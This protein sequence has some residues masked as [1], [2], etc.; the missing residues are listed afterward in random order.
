VSGLPPGWAEARLD[1]LAQVRLG[2]QRS[3][4][5]HSGSRMRPYLRAGN[6][7]WSG[8]DLRDVKEMN[9]TEEES[10]VYELQPGDVLVAEASGSA[11]EVGRPALWRGEIDGCCFQ[12][13]LIRVR[14]SGAQPE[15]L[16][17]FLLTEAQTGRIGRASPG[18]GIHHISGGRLAAWRVPLP[19]LA[20]Q[21][22]IVGA[23]EQQLSRLEAASTALFTAEDRI[24]LLR[25]SAS[26]S[27]FRDRWPTQP[28]AA[29]VDPERPI[30]YGILMPKEQVEDGVLYVRVRDFPAGR[31]LV[32]ELKRTSPEIANKYRRSA[33]KPDDV[34]VSIRGTFGRV[35]VVPPELDG[36]N[37]TQDT[38]R[39]AP[40]AEIDRD[41]LVAYLRSYPAQ[42]YFSV[43]ARGVA[44][45]GVNLG[46]LRAMPVPVPP[47][48]EQRRIAAEAE[49]TSSLLD[50]LAAEVEQT[51]RRCGVLRLA[52]LTRAFRGELVPQDP[53]EEPGRVLLELITAERATA[54]KP[55]R[56]RRERMPA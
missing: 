32:N 15:Y 35:A 31:I 21:R 29:L 4:K 52:I 23:L 10:G 39:I 34:L 17:Y 28:L 19:P 45:R 47:R 44:V 22:R 50:A 9:F 55:I 8:L 54:P 49:R 37:I 13:T 42:R 1:E 6:V 48:N 38:A 36:A 30:R 3:P 56:K 53:D 11:D 14:S 16:R 40:V 24:D 20:E 18:V 7:T 51:Q 43:V 46:D 2:R 12:N 5:N 26:A 41:Y 25:R 33:L 27:W